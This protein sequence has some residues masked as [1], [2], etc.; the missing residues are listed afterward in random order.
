MKTVTGLHEIKT[1]EHSYKETATGLNV[2]EREIKAHGGPIKTPAG[3]KRCEF[4][5]QFIPGQFRL[6][7][8]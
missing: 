1:P 6:W 3:P 5:I 8:W 4:E 2:K 7:F